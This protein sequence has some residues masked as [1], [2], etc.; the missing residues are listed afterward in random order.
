MG[1][2]RMST[3]LCRALLA[4]LGSVLVTTG[5]LLIGFEMEMP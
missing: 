3:T 4:L 2:R 5:A 1:G